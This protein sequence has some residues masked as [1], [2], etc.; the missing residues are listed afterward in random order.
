MLVKLLINSAHATQLVS[1]TYLKNQSN[2]FIVEELLRW[3]KQSDHYNPS[4]VT[5]HEK[6]VKALVRKLKR[7]KEKGGSQVSTSPSLHIHLVFF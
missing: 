6:A 3:K 1:Q 4:D 2:S 5:F 7:G